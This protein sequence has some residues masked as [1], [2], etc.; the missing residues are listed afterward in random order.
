MLRRIFEA[1]AVSLAG[2]ILMGALMFAIHL[3][4]D[5][6]A[7]EPEAIGWRMVLFLV[8]AVLWCGCQI[9]ALIVLMGTSL[10]NIG[11]SG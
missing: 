3:A 1:L 4:H 5:P 10:K 9:L 2:F 11:R 7:T 8:G 6:N